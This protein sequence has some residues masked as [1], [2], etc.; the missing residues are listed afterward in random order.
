MY[1]ASSFGYEEKV[2]QKL[3]PYSTQSTMNLIALCKAFPL[4]RIHAYTH[5]HTNINPH[6]DEILVVT[7]LPGE[8]N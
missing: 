7:Y 2:S 3:N 1:V 6:N 5:T 8:S 4:Q